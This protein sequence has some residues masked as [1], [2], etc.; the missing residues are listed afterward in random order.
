MQDMDDDLTE[1]EL[2]AR[3]DVETAELE[4]AT[5]IEEFRTI[6]VRQYRPCRDDQ[7]IPLDKFLAELRADNEQRSA[8]R[9]RSHG[10][11]GYPAS[12]GAVPGKPR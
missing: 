9:T 8:A 10:A 6:F 5:S 4:A 1:A 11:V 7:L 3:R 12:D 2:I